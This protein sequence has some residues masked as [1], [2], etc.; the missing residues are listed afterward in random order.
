MP[1]ARGNSVF[2]LYADGGTVY[3]RSS[4]DG[5][6]WSVATTVGS[7]TQCKGGPALGD[8]RRL[9]YRR[10]TDTKIY[11]D[12]VDAG[13]NVIQSGYDTGI[14]G[15]DDASFGYH[16]Y[17]YGANRVKFV[18]ECV[19]SGTVTEYTSDNGLDYS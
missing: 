5:V 13:G 12:I 4:A 8:G 18:I 10:D 1:N 2:L 14:S 19:V 3:E 6:T 16:C 7:G 17:P 9:R 11:A 15:V